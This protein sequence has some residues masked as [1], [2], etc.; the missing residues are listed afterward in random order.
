M[1]FRQ[2]TEPTDSQGVVPYI[3]VG[4]VICPKIFWLTNLFLVPS[5]LNLK[6]CLV[7]FFVWVFFLRTCFDYEIEGVGVEEDHV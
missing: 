6:K 2:K 5:N 4:L 3:F 1:R 7:S